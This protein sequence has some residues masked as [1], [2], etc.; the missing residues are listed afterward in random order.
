MQVI[1]A[2]AGGR[3]EHRLGHGHQR[4]RHRRCGG[5][6]AALDLLRLNTAECER[7]QACGN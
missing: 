2:V 5:G 4:R 1:Q 3:V 6:G 7:T